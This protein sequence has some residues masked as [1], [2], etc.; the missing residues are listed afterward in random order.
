MGTPGVAVPV[1][2]LKQQSL[3]R[4]KTLSTSECWWQGRR[5]S[6]SSQSLEKHTGK[7]EPRLA[8]PSI[9]DGLAVMSSSKMD[10][11]DLKQRFRKPVASDR[12]E[13]CWQGFFDALP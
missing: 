7:R 1:A 11:T 13:L 3:S 9:K 6:Q 10:M 5:I 12:D 2:T 4:G 8:G